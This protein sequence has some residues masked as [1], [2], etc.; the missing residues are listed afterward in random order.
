MGLYGGTGPTGEN[1]CWLPSCRLFKQEGFPRM[2]A[3]LGFVSFAM[4]GAAAWFYLRQ[5]VRE[6]GQPK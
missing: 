2:A 6:G 4:S 1:V 3:V 5:G